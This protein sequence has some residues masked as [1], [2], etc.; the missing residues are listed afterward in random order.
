[1]TGELSPDDD[2]AMPAL[3]TVG[4]GESVDGDRWTIEAGG[5]RAQ[6]LTVLLIDLPDGRS[7][8]GGLGGPTLPAGR[9][10]NMS[11]HRSDS[12]HT[13]VVGP[14]HPSVA[15]VRVDLDGAGQAGLD[16]DPTGDPARFGVRFVGAVL[17]RSTRAAV[18][19]ALDGAGEPLERDDHAPQAAILDRPA[20]SGHPSDGGRGGGWRPA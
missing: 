18:S 9:L 15:R 17:P 8:G 3:T 20:S 14:V 6:C 2:G 16:L 13:Y 11:W 1:M 5:T 19:W 12:G 4:Q 7:A 10:M